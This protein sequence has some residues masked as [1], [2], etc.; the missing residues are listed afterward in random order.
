[1]TSGM[2]TV[3]TLCPPVI[4][5]PDS[6]CARSSAYELLGA[7]FFG[8]SAGAL[9]GARFFGGTASASG[10]MPSASFAVAPAASTAVVAGSVIAEAAARAG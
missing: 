6:V 7:P 4:S 2:S 10:M 9:S 8:S 3:A 5:K 1:M